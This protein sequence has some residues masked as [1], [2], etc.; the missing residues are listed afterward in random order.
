VNPVGTIAQPSGALFGEFCYVTGQH[1][2]GGAGANDVDGGRTT[3]LSPILDLSNA[4]DASVEIQYWR[5]Y[6]NG[7][8]AAP[9][10]DVFTVDI[11]ND[12]GSTWV[13]VETVGP[14]GPEVNGG[15]F[16]VNF[17]PAT[18]ITLTDQVQLRF[19]AADEG[20]GSLVEAAIDGLLVRSTGCT[21]DPC[22]GDTTGDGKADQRVSIA[23]GFGIHIAYAGH[24]MHGLVW[25]P[26]GKLYW[27]IGDRGYHFTTKE[28]RHYDRPYT[29]G[30]FRCDPDGSNLEEVY[31][32]LR[33]P[34]EIAFD[35]Y[36]N[37]F[38]V[39]NDADF[40][41]ERERFLHQHASQ[42][43]THIQQLSSKKYTEQFDDTPEFT[44]LFLPSESF[45]SAALHSDPGLIERGVDHG[46]ILATPTTLIALLKA[47]AYGWRQ[48]ALA[49]NAKEISALGRTMHERLG[50]LA[51]HFSKLGH[52]LNNAV[53]S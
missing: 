48:E 21:A 5:W 4:K 51:E 52:S 45:F 26:D 29:G 28:G 12:G 16:Q 17:D 27:S 36:G 9:N 44:V 46:V 41:G 11:S 49:L 30:V 40:K 35:K 38:S 23:H 22:P 39:D 37:L 50:K 25:G 24:D 6:S 19:I 1:P 18:L 3:L 47:V 31:S 8:G 10:A 32:G 15:W 2:G 53:G 14:G 20:A 42:V 7:A 13:N 33:N 34:Q 43:R